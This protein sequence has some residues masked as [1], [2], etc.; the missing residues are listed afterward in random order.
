MRS[1]EWYQKV[2][3]KHHHV[4]RDSKTENLNAFSDS[5]RRMGAE[6]KQEQKR[7][8]FTPKS[9]LL[10][11]IIIILLL[12]LMCFYSTTSPSLIIPGPIAFYEAIIRGFSTDI[13]PIHEFA[14]ICIYPVISSP[15]SLIL[16]GMSFVFALSSSAYPDKLPAYE[17]GSDPSDDAR[18]RFDIRFY[19]VSI[20]FII[21]DLEVTSPSP[22]A[23]PPNKIGWFGF[24]SMMVFP[25][26]LTIGFIYE[27]KKGAL[28]RE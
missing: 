22:R 21:L 14:P 23:V 8:F 5:I 13:P 28:D 7:L 9:R 10:S 4:H 20:P 25:R 16:I 1:I 3:W 26:I 11:I 12:S 17:C 6:G 24:W 27:W 19:P 2:V 18:S 15:L